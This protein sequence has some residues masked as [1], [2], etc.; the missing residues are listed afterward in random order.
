QRAQMDKNFAH[1]NLLLPAGFEDELDADGNPVRDEQGNFKQHGQ[2]IVIHVVH[3]VK[4][5]L[6]QAWMDDIKRYVPIKGITTN[7]ESNTPDAESDMRSLLPFLSVVSAAKKAEAA[8]WIQAA[9]SKEVHWGRKDG[10]T[11]MMFNPNAPAGEQY[12][13]YPKDAQGNYVMPN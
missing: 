7:T 9:Q 4:F 3:H 8:G 12:R 1:E 13:E 5:K 6:P 11:P 10:K 2:V